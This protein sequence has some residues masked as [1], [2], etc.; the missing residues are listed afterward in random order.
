[1]EDH[2]D[3]GSYFAALDDWEREQDARLVS[4][5]RRRRMRK[6]ASDRMAE[7]TNVIKVRFV[8]DCEAAG[9]EYTYYALEPVKVGDIVDVETDRGTVQA[10][11]SR[12]NVPQEEI[13]RFGSR[14]RSINGKTLCRCETCAQLR[15]DDGHGN[16]ACEYSGS[17]WPLVNGCPT[18]GYLWCMGCFY[19]QRKAGG[20]H[21]APPHMGR[22]GEQMQMSMPAPVRTPWD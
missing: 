8:K 13:A 17:K 14:A 12:V 21:E 19:Q 2:D 20:V 15:P 1:M 22:A 5:A 4:R 9:R 3:P 6:E 11:V 7:V 16:R 10:Q 18:S